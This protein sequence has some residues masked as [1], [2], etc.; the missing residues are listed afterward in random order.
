[1]NLY[2]RNF[3]AICCIG[4]ISI[5]FLSNHADAQCAAS[6]DYGGQDTVCI[7]ATIVLTDQSTSQLGIGDWNWTVNG[8][9]LQGTADSATFA[10]TDDGI[11]EIILTVYEIQGGCS[12][13]DT[14][15]IV[16]LGNPVPQ[17]D[18]VNISC[19]GLCDGT[20]LVFY[21]SPN[22]GAY[23]A[24]WSTGGIAPLTNLCAGM[25]AATISDGFG[26][27]PPAVSAQGEV[28]EPSQL[29]SNISNGAVVLGCE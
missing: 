17:L 22:A 9:W 1:M 24:T 3:L 15:V 28:I 25:Y 14:V 20:A 12:D 2:K 5:A 21:D 11:Y 23:T 27:T 16:V 8:A 10:P 26:C 7:N 6:F 29:T 19:H 4:L 18:I 13:R